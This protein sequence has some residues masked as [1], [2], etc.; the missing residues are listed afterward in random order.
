M[1]HELRAP[2]NCDAGLRS[3]DDPAEGMLLDGDR[4]DVL[5]PSGLGSAWS[6]PTS[7]S[8][9]RGTRLEATRTETRALLVRS[10]PG[11]STI[12]VSISVD[13]FWASACAVDGVR[14][15][16]PSCLREVS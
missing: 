14:L 4:V 15:N 13:G 9:K 12:F 8:R 11:D 1:G 7:A 6:G 3:P 2:A 10:D 5:A 16:L